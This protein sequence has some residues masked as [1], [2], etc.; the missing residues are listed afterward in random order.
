MRIV[1]PS[2]VSWTTRCGSILKRRGMP[3]ALPS[4]VGCTTVK[5]APGLPAFAFEGYLSGVP[6]LASTRDVDVASGREGAAGAAA[7]RGGPAQPAGGGRPGVARAGDGVRPRGRSGAGEWVGRVAA[8]ERPHPGD[9]VGER[10]AGV[11]ARSAW[12]PVRSLVLRGRGGGAGGAGAGARPRRGRARD[13]VAA[14]LS[15]GGAQRAG[16][17]GAGRAEPGVGPL[18]RAGR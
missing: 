9:A 7:R 17:G 11:A 1:S 13:A 16:A 12:A 4:F 10:R 2:I 5:R 14:P 3:E 6:A 8:G 18:A 15:P